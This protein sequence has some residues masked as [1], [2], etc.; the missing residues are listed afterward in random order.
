[1]ASQP[2]ILHIAAAIVTMHER[3]DHHARAAQSPPSH[4]HTGDT[5]ADALASP[6]SFCQG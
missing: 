6:F 4:H 5:V 1:M 2:R 3:C